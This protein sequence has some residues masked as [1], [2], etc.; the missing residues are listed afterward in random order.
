MLQKLCFSRGK[1]FVRVKKKVF[2]FPHVFLTQVDNNVRVK[3]R[4]FESG[5]NFKIAICGECSKLP[6]AVS[7]CSNWSGETRESLL[8]HLKSNCRLGFLK[9]GPAYSKIVNY[10]P[11]YFGIVCL[12]P[13]YFCLVQMNP[14]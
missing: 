11:M 12:S 8:C 6:T 9:K 10:S 13:V 14:V 1:N 2:C 4:R 3:G 5:Q 7:F